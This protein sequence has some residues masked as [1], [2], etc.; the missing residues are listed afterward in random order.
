LDEDHSAQSN[1]FWMKISKNLL[2]HV[3]D[4][5]HSAQNNMF[6][7]KIGKNV[8]CLPSFLLQWLWLCTKHHF[9]MKICKTLL[10]HVLDE[11]H[12]A[13]NNMF[14]MKIGKNVICLPSFL[15]Q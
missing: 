12:A 13:Q 14:W 6:W 3:L 11:E 15:L 7:M 4:E 9:W 5:D 10:G 2:H 8:I 1:M